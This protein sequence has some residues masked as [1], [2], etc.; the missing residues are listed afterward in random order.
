MQFAAIAVLK[1]E[2]AL[3][4]AKGIQIELLG[5]FSPPLPPFSFHLTNQFIL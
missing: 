5:L 3:K 4:G 1:W 2:A